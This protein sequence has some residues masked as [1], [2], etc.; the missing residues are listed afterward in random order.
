MSTRTNV[1][2]DEH[3]IKELLPHRYP[4]LLIDSVHEFEELKRVVASKFISEDYP[5]FEG[6]FPN[7]PIYP[8]VYFI[9]SMAQ[10]GAL[11]LLKNDK[12]N[13]NDVVGL[14]SSVESARFRKPIRLG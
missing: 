6:H 3:K 9:E 5:V 1:L 12:N 10:T 14:L 7:N 11:L 8:G 13:A 2:M 4:L